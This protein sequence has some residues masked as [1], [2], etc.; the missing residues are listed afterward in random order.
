M[1]VSPSIPLGFEWDVKR[2]QL[3]ISS[4][5]GKP[6]NVWH[7]LSMNAKAGHAFHLLADWKE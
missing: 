5:R 3:R 4:R 7:V 2:R 1:A 6:D